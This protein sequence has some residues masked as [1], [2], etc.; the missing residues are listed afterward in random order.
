MTSNLGT[1]EIGSGKNL[2]FHAAELEDDYGS[3]EKKV[4]GELKKAFNPE[5]L[6][7][8]DET[9]VF[10]PLDRDSIVKIIDIML[11]DVRKRLEERG[12]GIMVSQGAKEYI[13]AEGYNPMYG[14]RPLRRAIQ[15]Y[16]ENPLSEELIQ[17][18]FVEGSII[19]V[20]E[21]DGKLIFG[22]LRNHTKR[23]EKS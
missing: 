21:K 10:K 15:R 17:G 4:M 3:M 6:N 22:E 19:H 11:E 2:G 5:F 9:V 23:T 14:A 8:I 13:A 7:R 16:V 20:E 1:R 12:I 18:K